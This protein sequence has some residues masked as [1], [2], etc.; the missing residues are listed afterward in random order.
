ME[1]GMIP[2][3]VAERPPDDAELA[4]RIGQRDERAF[5]ALM[6]RH[7][8]MLYRLARSIL[9]DEAEAE[10]AVQEQA[11]GGARHEAQGQAGRQSDQPEPQEGWRG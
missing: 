7:N 8:R 11:G 1:R 10:D 2:Q 3:A 4:R 9:K 5:E 6:R